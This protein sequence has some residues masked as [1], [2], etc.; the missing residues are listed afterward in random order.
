MSINIAVCI[1][2]VP[3]PD[4]YNRM[5]IDP[6]KKTLVREGI[7]SVIN[8][9]DMHALELALSLREKFG[10]EVTVVSMAPPEAKEQLFEALAFGAD[11]AYLLSDRRVGGADTLATSYTLSVLLKSIGKFDLILAGNESADGAT[12][13]VPSQLGEWLAMPHMTDAV[14]LTMESETIVQ[15]TKQLENGCANYKIKLPA[16]IAVKKKINEVRYLTAKGILTAKN[17]PIKILNRD[18]LLDLDDALIGYEGS[19]TQAGKLV[20][21]EYKRNGE[22]IEGNEEKI[23][24]TILEKINAIIN[25]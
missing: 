9:T 8:E 2:S 19:P 6:V 14:N 11:K 18:D 13:H 20:T 10:G 22:L 12:A 16:V 3:N 24:E 7:P 5:T 4:Y 21:V 23:A 15:V 25:N 1:K 17:K